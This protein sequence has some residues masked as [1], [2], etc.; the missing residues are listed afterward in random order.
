MY[1]M[2]VLRPALFLD[3]DGVINEEIGYLHR[4]EDVRFL[5]GAAD[6]IRTANQ[7]G[8]S[9]IVITNQAGI[10]RGYYTEAQFHDLMASMRAALLR[11]G[12][13]L[14]AIY[15]SPYHPQHGL[16]EY[17]Q[18]TECRKPRPGML[19]RAAAEHALDLSR[20]VLVGDRCSDLLA[21]EAAGVPH[22]FLVDGTEPEGCPASKHTT[23]T[24]LREVTTWLGEHF[25]AARIAGDAVPA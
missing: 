22:R 1:P 12:A 9:T 16:G 11:D 25:R 13:R 3:R 20:S 8:V 23:V 21:G 10:G 24:E 15:F 5:P 6:L 14:D 18:E 17:R 7:L 4:F 19:L 2:E